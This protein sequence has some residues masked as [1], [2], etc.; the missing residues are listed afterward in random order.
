MPELLRIGA[1]ERLG[2]ALKRQM[3]FCT[4]S[5]AGLLTGVGFTKEQLTQEACKL[6]G[7]ELTRLGLAKLLLQQ[8]DLLLL[9]EPTN[10][11]DLEALNWLEEYLMEYRGAVIVVSH[12]R[13][14]LD[15]ICTSVTEIHF[16]VSETYQGNYSRY[17]AQRTQRFDA[18]QKA[19]DLQQRKSN[20]SRKS[21]HAIAASTEKNPS[22]LLKVAKG[23]GAYGNFGKA[24]G[25]KTDCVPFSGTTPDGGRRTACKEFVQGL[26]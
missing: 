1:Y 7:G 3:V 26:R 9:D 22:A 12:D 17:I 20:A 19:Y 25:R 16:G 6:S 24:H 15:R 13:Y 18:R 5:R 21:L 2:R 4:I 10:H 23:A 14:F 11:L 8:P